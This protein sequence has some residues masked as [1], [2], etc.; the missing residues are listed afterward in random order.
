LESTNG[1]F[2]SNNLPKVIEITKASPSLEEIK[3][4]INFWLSNKH[5]YLAGKSE[6]NL[7]KVARE[8]LIKRTIKEREK[9]IK[10]GFV[11]ERNAKIEK[12]ELISQTSSRIVVLVDL[13]FS[14][15]LI[16]KSGELI[17][18]TSQPLKVKYTFGFQ[19]KS[20][21]MVDFVPGL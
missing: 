1:E 6:I 13:S 15:K 20:W 5:S 9:N 14:E 2:K 21:K 8:G 12:I 19:D 18:E 17:S 7:S 16:K 10:K 3:N 4:L 11:T